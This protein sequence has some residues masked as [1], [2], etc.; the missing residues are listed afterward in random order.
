VTAVYAYE[1]ESWT[2]HLMITIPAHT[3]RKRSTTLL[4]NFLVF[5]P[6]SL[7]PVYK[8]ASI[9]AIRD[10]LLLT[11]PHALENLCCLVT[12]VR[13]CERPAENVIQQWV[14]I[15]AATWEL[16]VRHGLDASMDWMDPSIDWIGQGVMT[17]SRFFVYQ[18]LAIPVLSRLKITIRIVSLRARFNT[19]HL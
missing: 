10:L 16:R 15:E 18:L 6:L 1:G 13:A 11:Y 12:D 7:E 8:F 9:I 4:Q 17:V 2:R 5:L 14:R 19:R 3:Q